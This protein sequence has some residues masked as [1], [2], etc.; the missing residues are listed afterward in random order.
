MTEADLLSALV[1][2][3]SVGSLV[4]GAYLMLRSQISRCER[5][6]DELTAGGRELGRDLEALAIRV[7]RLEAARQ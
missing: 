3:G 4:L 2:S 1:G 6:L 7:V 5:K